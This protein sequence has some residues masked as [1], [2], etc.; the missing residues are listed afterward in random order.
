MHEHLNKFQLWNFFYL[1]EYHSFMSLAKQT[2]NW[3]EL[4]ETDTQHIFSSTCSLHSR[5]RRHH[6]ATKKLQLL[7]ERRFNLYHRWSGMRSVVANRMLSILGE[8]GKWG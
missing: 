6:W 2:Q 5:G 1:R 8:K 3:T 4:R 7:H